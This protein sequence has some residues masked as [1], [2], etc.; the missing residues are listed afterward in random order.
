MARPAD[1]TA[2][3]AEARAGR[4]EAADALFAHLYDELRS[5][6]HARL[7]DQ[8][9][10]A[11]LD[12]TGLVHEAYLRLI[13]RGRVS[14]S[15]RAHFL[16]LSARAMRFVLLDRARARVRLKRG[17]P[18]ADLSLDGLQVAA[19]DGQ[20]G[21]RALELLALDAALEK[22]RAHSERLAEIV[23]WRYFGGLTYAEM[24]EV[25]GRSVAT[26][27][28]DWVRARLWLYRLMQ[29]APMDGEA[30]ER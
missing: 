7:S 16:A 4:R 27:E 25:S 6:A 20:G 17:G 23:E 19:G 9:T 30:E 14:P 15:D 22:L 21:D 8:P 10:S 29:E 26:L 12:T 3:L 13:D 2:L 24:A 1:T 18:Q 11:T 5:L 28:R